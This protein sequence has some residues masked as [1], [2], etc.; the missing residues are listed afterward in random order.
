MRNRGLRTCIKRLRASISS[1][2]KKSFGVLEHSESENISSIIQIYDYLIKSHEN[3]I[4]RKR[5]FHP[6]TLSICFVIMFYMTEKESRRIDFEKL[7]FFHGFLF[8]TYPLNPL[9]D[10]K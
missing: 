7:K 1:L 5:V 8:G 6:M 3:S 4:I 9:L 10:Q 2:R